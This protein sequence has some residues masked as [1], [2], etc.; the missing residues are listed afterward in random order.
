MAIQKVSDLSVLTNPVY[1]SEQLNN[2]LLEISYPIDFN[3][4]YTKYQSMSI[5]YKDIADTILSGVISEESV[6]LVGQKYFRDTTYFMSGIELSGNLLVNHNIPDDILRQYDEKDHHSYIK[7]LNNTIVAL[8]NIDDPSNTGINL[9]CADNFNKLYATENEF[10][11]NNNEFRDSEGDL[12]V[13]IYDNRVDAFVDQN[14]SCG[15]VNVDSGHIK[16]QSNN[17]EWYN[18]SNVRMA[19][20]DGNNFH[21]KSDIYGCAMSA[22][23]ADLAELYETDYIYKPGTLVK[24]GGEKEITIATD[25]ANAVITTKP[26]FT[27][28]S[29]CKGLSQGIALTG[30]TPVRV[31]G[32]LNKFDNIKLS[33][34]PGVAVK[35]N[36][37]SDKIV[38]K[39][40]QSKTI[41][42]EGLVECVVKL[43]F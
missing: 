29:D 30:R 42:E 24:F 39:S 18:K 5:R 15:N 4:E 6:L 38:G 14:I 11:S 27:M 28:N 34:I 37:N 32:K 23:W 21:F 12:I 40:L 1:K 16:Y 20:F 33:D 25:E 13:G 19:Y 2:T 17:V 10:H 43:T 3:T 36:D 35:S 8:K 22:R 7:E 31:I 9:L 26:A 41:D